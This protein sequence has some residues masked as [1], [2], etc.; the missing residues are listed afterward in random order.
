MY[1]IKIINY[2]DGELSPQEHEEVI[3]RAPVITRKTFKEVCEIIGGK[4][5]KHTGGWCA[6]AGNI[7][8]L[9]TKLN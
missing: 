9:I 4:P 2:K 3:T 7:E 5:Y 8:Y 6:L 1:Q